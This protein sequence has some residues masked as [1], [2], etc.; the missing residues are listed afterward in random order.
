MQNLERSWEDRERIL[1]DKIKK[2]EGRVMERMEEM[3]KKNREDKE[4]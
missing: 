2:L 3:G 1:M 4:K